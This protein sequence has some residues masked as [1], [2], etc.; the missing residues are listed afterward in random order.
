MLMT[1]HSS[2]AVQRDYTPLDL[3]NLRLRSKSCLRWISSEAF[4]PIWL[5]LSKDRCRVG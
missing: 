1:G 4:K 5:F 3:A 2:V